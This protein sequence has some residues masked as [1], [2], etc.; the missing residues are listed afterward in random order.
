VYARYASSK[1]CSEGADGVRIVA[2]HLAQGEK[3][4][5]Q[6]NICQ[7]LGFHGGDHDEWRLLGCYSV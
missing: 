3:S 2:Y 4:R 6:Q 1:A 7:I 5:K